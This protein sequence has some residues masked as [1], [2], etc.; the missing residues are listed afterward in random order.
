MRVYYLTGANFALSNLALRRLRISRFSGLNDPFELLPVDV[1]KSHYRD[2]IRKTKE[3]INA[4]K[5]LICF[6]KVSPL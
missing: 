3:H 5:G 2:A 6:S 1:G 4:S